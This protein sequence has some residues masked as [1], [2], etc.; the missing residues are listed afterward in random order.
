MDAMIQQLR[1]PG[2]QALAVAQR[3][4]DVKLNCPLGGEFEFTPLPTA[5][6]PNGRAS[7]PGWWTSSAWSAEQLQNDGTVGPPPGY[8]APWLKWFRGAQLHLT[9][10]PDRLAVVGTVEAHRQPLAPDAGGE[11]KVAL[12]PMNF[13]LFQLPFNLFGGKA[14][15]AAPPKPQTR[16]F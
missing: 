7:A 4:L 3:V 13:D 12:P 9:Q 1:V 15:E 14:G 6:R 16:K 2:P 8:I 10:F 11:E 5:E